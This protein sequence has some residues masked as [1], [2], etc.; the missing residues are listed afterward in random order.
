MS[1]DRMPD[2]R[3]Q[4]QRRAQRRDYDEQ[5]RIGQG[6][7]QPGPV[8]AELAVDLPLLTRGPFVVGC[9]G[10]PGPRRRPDIGQARCVHAQLGRGAEQRRRCGAAYRVTPT[11]DVGQNQHGSGVLGGQPSY[12]LRIEVVGDGDQPGQTPKR[13]G[14]I[15]HS[16]DPDRQRSGRSSRNRAVHATQAHDRASSR[17]ADPCSINGV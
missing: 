16:A 17:I 11:Y 1:G 14:Q 7:A 9:A 3:G 6:P 15:G 8:T 10:P 4:P 12:R 2:S 13:L 5:V